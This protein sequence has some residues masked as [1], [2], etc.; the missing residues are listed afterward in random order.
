MNYKLIKIKLE[1]HGKLILL[2]K[3][4]SKLYGTDTA[5]SDT[6][7][8]G[9]FVPHMDKLL[10]KNDVEFIKLDTN[11]TGVS[12]TIYD[13]DCH[14]DS[15]HKWLHLLQ[16]GETN[17]LDTLFAVWTDN[18]VYIDPAFKEFL[19]QNYLSLITSNPHAFVGYCISQTR[20]YNIRG[21]RYNEVEAFYRYLV[22]LPFDNETKLSEFVRRIKQYIATNSNKFIK[23]V[24]APGPRGSK[25]EQWVYLEI[26][27]RK[28]AD[29]VTLGY[30]KDKCSDMVYS[31]GS[32]VVGNTDAIDWKAMSHAV[33][34][35]LEVEELLSTSF[36]KFPLQD[37]EYIKKVKAGQVAIDD[38]QQLLHQKIELVDS[39]LLSTTLN[40]E[41]CTDTV[42]RLILS[43]YKD[44]V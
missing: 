2:T 11:K 22:E 17:A 1:E 29:N 34:V 7:Y 9:V 19:L 36:I 12:N 35:I 38:V 27:G 24:Q 26:L 30:L 21:T 39:L 23:F 15:L 43:F 32:R 6:D 8:K 28:F 37:R 31:Y 14:I 16:K 10:L 4:G 3:S 40:K 41:V 13:I 5:S 25:I 18:I 44:N 33:R 20:K 42:H